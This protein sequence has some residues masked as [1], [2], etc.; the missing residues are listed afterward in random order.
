[1]RCS[2]GTLG[3]APVGDASG[4]SLNTIILPIRVTM[5]F[6]GTVF[7]IRPFSAQ[8]TLPTST[9]WIR[10]TCCAIALLPIRVR[11]KATVPYRNSLALRCSDGHDLHPRKSDEGSAVPIPLDSQPGSEGAQSGP[12]WA[13]AI[14]LKQ[15][16]V[17]KCRTAA[18]GREQS[19]TTGRFRPSA[20]GR[21]MG[22]ASPEAATSQTTNL[23]PLP[24]TVGWL[25]ASNCRISS[26]LGRP[27]ERAQPRSREASRIGSFCRRGTMHPTTTNSPARSTCSDPQPE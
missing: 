19:W 7:T 12:W 27:F 4:S 5:S 26:R 15:P 20:Y 16:V 3:P 13:I 25:I 23:N 11:L 6:V 24:P 17:E 10:C 21:I 1:M 14:S 8:F 9:S 22:V 2:I 18:S